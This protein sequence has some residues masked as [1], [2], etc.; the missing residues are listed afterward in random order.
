MWNIIV[1]D[2]EIIER[3]ITKKVLTDYY[4][5]QCTVYDTANGNEAIQVAKCHYIHIAVMDISMPG[6]NGIDASREILKFHPDCR[7][8]FLTAYEDFN[9]V[10][11]ALSI[12]AVDYLLK[13]CSD[14]ELINAVDTAMQSYNNL[15]QY[16]KFVDLIKFPIENLSPDTPDTQNERNSFDALKIISYIKTNYEKDLSLCD[17]A[18]RFGYSEVYFCKYFKQ[19][20]NVNFTTFLTNLRMDKAKELLSD[21]SINIKTI[22]NQVG[23]ADPNYF[24]K[25]FKRIVGVTPSEFRAD[26]HE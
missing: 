4:K 10:R 12:H 5:E 15:A 11:E 21:S 23:Y 2:D 26:H 3:M 14:D 25:V 19:N 18:A 7:I 6:I 8:I 20:F 1:S 9:Y 16:Q 13:P 22:G 17:V 24:S